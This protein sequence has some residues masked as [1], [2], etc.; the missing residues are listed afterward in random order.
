MDTPT[1]FTSK[2]SLLRAKPRGRVCQLK[3]PSRLY[4]YI[5]VEKMQAMRF[6]T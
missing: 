2:W 6:E 5:W 1:R 4:I 3:I